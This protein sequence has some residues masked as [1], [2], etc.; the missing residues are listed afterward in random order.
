MTPLQRSD[1]TYYTE[2]VNLIRV[3]DFKTKIEFPI[4]LTDIT[5]LEKINRTGSN[6]IPFRI[7]V[8][9]EDPITGKV[10]LIRS[11]PLDDGTNINVLL[12][13]FEDDEF[14]H[15]HYVLLD[16]MSV[17]RKRYINSKN[18]AISY[19]NTIFCSRCFE[20]FRSKP[21]LENHVKVCGKENHIK[22]F[23]DKDE[24]IEY[25][26]HEN[27]FK[28]IFTGYAD[29]ESVLEDTHNDLGCS[30]CISSFD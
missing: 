4:A 21:L 27:N 12:I 16:G 9:R 28:R 3:S 26:N 24:R 6:P 5:E 7:N 17:F 29:F 10:H 2:F 25:K 8:F 1:P 15:S 19:A 18:A 13:D 11:S 22:V 30:D 20:H 23:P 14:E